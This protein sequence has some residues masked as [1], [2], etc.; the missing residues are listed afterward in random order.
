[1]K[2]QNITAQ[3]STQESSVKR[4]RPSRFSTVSL[5][6]IHPR[7][8][9]KSQLTV[10]ADGL[11][12]HLDEIWPDVGPDNG[13]LGGD[14]DNWERGPYYLD[15]LIPVSILLGSTD[16]IEKAEPWICWT[17]SSQ[18]SDGFFGPKNNAD[19]WARMVMMKALI[20]YADSN[21]TSERYR[22]IIELLDRFLRYMDSHLDTC[23]LEMWAYARG[24]E[25]CTTLFW[26][27]EETGNTWYVDFASRLFAVSLDWDA[28]FRSMPYTRPVGEYIPWTE[29]RSYM[30]HIEAD[31]DCPTH[32]DRNK[33]EYYFETYHQ[34]HGVNIAMAF[35]YLAYQYQLTGDLTYI[36]HLWSGYHQ[37][38]A[39]H[40]QIT[41][42]YSCDE[43]LNGLNP[44]QGTELCT[45]V[46]FLYSTE[47]IIRIT[48]DMRWAD[49]FER[50]GYNALPAPISADACSHQYNQQVNQIS[51]TVA[52]RAWYNNKPNSNIFGLEPN[53]GC[54]TANMHQGWPKFIRSLWMR[55]DD[56]GL[57]C[58]SYA[59][60]ELVEV[61]DSV[62]IRIQVHSNYPFDGD[63]R[64]S[65]SAE[66][67][68]RFP[69]R[70]HIPSWAEDFSLLVNDHDLELSDS[71]TDSVVLDRF[72]HHD[73]LLINFPMSIRLEKTPTGGVSVHRGPLIYALAL[74]DEWRLLED[75]GRFSDW[76]IIPRQNWNF[77]L[78][79]STKDSWE[80][81]KSPC[82]DMRFKSD[83]APVAIQAIGTQVTNWKEKEFSAGPLPS[84]C[85]FTIEDRRILT[86]VPYGATTL[87]IADFPDLG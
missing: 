77:G 83:L 16:L 73:E 48:G 53:F 18:Q 28:F 55:E 25:T 43:H 34:T 19:W 39:A 40:G 69:L 17:L 14:G 21:R 47:E 50:V 76:E 20:Q 63:I 27:Y 61:I 79:S 62:H 86:L 75:R 11:T 72:W 78:F 45:V 29:Y 35:K 10:L 2:N 42:L 7:G 46:E 41:G 56:R 74:D 31:I 68:I 23:P 80:V 85:D 57:V 1:M 44:S 37:I 60:V 3:Q 15:G 22:Q 5:N 24:P 30:A 66:T 82:W 71:D 32:L 70:L 54:C 8:W 6:H 49:I 38:L 51:C 81:I 64:I 52:P 4:Y 33:H 67:P 36:D 13:W 9:T 84:V 65:V 12:G 58:L 59:P 26:L 87:R